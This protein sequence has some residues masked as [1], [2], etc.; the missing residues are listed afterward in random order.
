[1]KQQRTARTRIN[2]V[3]DGPSGSGEM[4]VPLYV[5]VVSM[6]VRARAF[7]KS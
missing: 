6:A 1:M 5:C 7:K 4:V 2:K 3:C